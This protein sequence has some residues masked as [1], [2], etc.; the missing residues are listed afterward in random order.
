VE[1]DDAGLVEFGSKLVNEGI[2]GVAVVAVPVAKDADTAGML[3]DCPGKV[4]LVAVIL[5]D[6]TL[7]MPRGPLQTDVSAEQLT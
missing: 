1:F 5:F 7:C 2:R 3:I 4:V 6:K